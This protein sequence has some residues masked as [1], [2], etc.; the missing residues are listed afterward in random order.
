[1]ANKFKKKNLMFILERFLDL[2]SKRAIMPIETQ[3][4]KKILIP[5]LLFRMSTIA[6]KR[7]LWRTSSKRRIK[8][9]FLEDVWI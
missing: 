6:T 1:V 8:F 5:F 2:R 7:T 3:A 9:L 4:L